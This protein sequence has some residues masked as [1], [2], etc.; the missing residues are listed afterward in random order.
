MLNVQL[1]EEFYMNKKVIRVYR[2]YLL[3]IYR[4][5]ISSCTPPKVFTGSVLGRN[6]YS[7]DKNYQPRSGRHTIT[8]SLARRI[9]SQIKSNAE[10][11]IIFKASYSFIW[12]PPGKY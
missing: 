3:S 4:V 6:E 10:L 1:F 12:F 8:G 5:S 2:S 7:M 11:F 9:I